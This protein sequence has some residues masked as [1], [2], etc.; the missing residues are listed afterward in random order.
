LS[1]GLERRSLVTRIRDPSDRRAYQMALTAEG[2]RI[3]M[4]SYDA[5]TASVAAFTRGVA[6]VDTKRLAT[7]LAGILAEHGAPVVVGPVVR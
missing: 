6:T 2:A 3:G 5:V 7:I 4:A 1:I